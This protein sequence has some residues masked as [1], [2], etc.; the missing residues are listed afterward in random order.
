M[1][2]CLILVLDGKVLFMPDYF[3]QLNEKSSDTEEALQ[4]IY[5]LQ[6]S[7]TPFTGFPEDQTKGRITSSGIILGEAH[8]NKDY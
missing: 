2:S 6:N 7:S 4:I 8:C 3:F 5:H 1:H